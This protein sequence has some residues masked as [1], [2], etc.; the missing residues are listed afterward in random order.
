MKDILS[1]IQDRRSYYSISKKSPIS[2]DRIY[3]IVAEAVKHTPSS[4]NMQSQ[5]VVLLLGPAN[6][7]LWNIVVESLRVI[8]PAAQFEM[9][10]KKIKKLASGYGSILFYDDTAITNRFS[11]QFPLYREK[12]AVWSQ[13]ANAMLQIN[14]WNLLEAEGFGAS[15]QHYNPL[16]DADVQ[17]A[18]NLPESW[19]LIAQMPFGTPT[20]APDEKEF[21]P[22][23]E[24]VKFFK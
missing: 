3:K 16:I 2:D 22:I 13:H 6:D 23:E 7:Q 24:R 15:L 8:V 17:K 18:W 1:S 21:T 10:E 19:S 14:I 11:N 5:R 9:T 12:F 20:A 4:Y